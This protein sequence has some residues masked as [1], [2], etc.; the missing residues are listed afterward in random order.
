MR[1][2]LPFAIRILSLSEKGAQACHGNGY[3]DYIVNVILYESDTLLYMRRRKN[4]LFGGAVLL[5][6]H[7]IRS[8]V[9]L[10]GSG[11]KAFDYT[12]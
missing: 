3:N 7:T 12:T 2:L 5:E 1:F 4:V 11:Q 8:E 10:I 6:G 9:F